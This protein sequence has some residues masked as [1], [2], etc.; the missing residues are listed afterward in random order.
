M[1]LSHKVTQSKSVNSDNLIYAAKD[2]I[3]AYY[4]H[5]HHHHHYRWGGEGKG[6][7][8]LKLS[9]LQQLSMQ[10]FQPTPDCSVFM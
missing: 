1:L 4:N 10:P 5:H 8:G 2:G 3:W 6:G 9:S 7:E